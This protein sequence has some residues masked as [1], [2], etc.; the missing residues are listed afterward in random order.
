MTIPQKKIHPR[1]PC[2]EKKSCKQWHRKKKKSRNIRLQEKV[3]RNGSIK[4]KNIEIHQLCL[5]TNLF[6]KNN[7][8]SGF[9]FPNAKDIL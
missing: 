8:R 7:K 3:R 5:S 1:E 4:Q 2:L 9:L 6:D